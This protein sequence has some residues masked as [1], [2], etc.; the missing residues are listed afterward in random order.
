MRAGKTHG[1]LPALLAVAILGIGPA[2]AGEAGHLVGQVTDEEGNA[3]PGARLTLTGSGASSIQSV[4]ADAEGRFRVF[5]MDAVR[6]LSILAEAEGKV[7]VEYRE[8]RVKPDRLNRLDIRLRGEGAHDV[9]ILMDKRVPYH[10][11]ALAGARTTLP[12]RAHLLDFNEVTPSVTR[13]ILRA[14]ENQPSAVLAIG[15]EAARAARS[16]AREVPVVHTMVPD[17]LPGEMASENL[18]GIALIGGFN[19][20]L[21]RLGRLD[22]ELRTIG[23]IYDPSRLTHAVARFREAAAEAGMS[24]VVGHVHQREDFPGALRSLA[25]K[26]LDAFV[27]LMDP[28]VYTAHNFAL[29]R[30]FAEEE[31]LFLVVPDASMAG[32]G[33]SFSFDPGFWE[34]GAVAGRIVRDIVE[35]R[36]TPT[37]VGV[38]QPTDTELAA[39]TVATAPALAWT[40]VLGDAPPLLGA[41]AVA[42]ELR[43]PP[44]GEADKK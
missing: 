44:S 11:L 3:V 9:L 32:P 23:T 7:P 24:L 21:E 33:K 37:D 22:P 10:R 27:V 28:E 38:R 14:L 18:C 20:Q 43:D 26:G 19:R 35:G 36:L 41:V 4:T 40:P 2:A 42:A 13:E 25:G 17:P 5:V 34:S 16:L 39:V 8:Y 12:G 6:P 15:E 30:Q 29:V 1:L 31:D